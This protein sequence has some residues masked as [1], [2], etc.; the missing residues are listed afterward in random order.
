MSAQLDDFFVSDEHYGNVSRFDEINKKIDIIRKNHVLFVKRNLNVAKYTFLLSLLINIALVLRMIFVEK[1]IVYI[2][3]LI[4]V[5][6]IFLSVVSF[7]SYKDN[8]ETYKMLIAYEITD[9][10]SEEIWC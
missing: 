9:N 2:G 7:K 3:L 1:S 10:L 5:G 4:I 6:F 8:K